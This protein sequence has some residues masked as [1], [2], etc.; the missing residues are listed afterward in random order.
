[1]E[2]ESSVSRHWEVIDELNFNSVSLF[3]TT[4][5]FILN[6]DGSFIDNPQNFSAALNILKIIIVGA[7][8]YYINIVELSTHSP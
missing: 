3:I 6:G 7:S 5:Y 1:M 4:K 2:L 8:Y